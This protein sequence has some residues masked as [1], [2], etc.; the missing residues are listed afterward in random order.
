MVCSHFTGMAT[1]L[2]AITLVAFSLSSCTETIGSSEITGADPGVLEAPIAF[3]KRPIPV[4]DNDNE[5]QSDLREPLFFAAGGDIYLR[6]NSTVTA[7]ELNITA[8]ITAGQGDVKD[9]KPSFDGTRLL[10]SLRLFDPNPNDDDTPSW[11][12]YEYDLAAKTTRRIISNDLTAEQGDDIGPAYLPDG[13]IVFSSNRQRQSGEMLTNEGKPRFRALDED[14]N[15]VAMVLHVMDSDGGNLQQISFNQSHDLDPLVLSNSYPGEIA[16]T[17]WDNTASNDAMHLYKINPDGSALQVLYGVHS[18]D[19]GTNNAGTNDSTIQFTQAEEMLD[20]RIMAITR[21]Y[22]GTYGGGNIVI[23]DIENFVNQTQPVFNMTGLPGPAQTPATINNVSTAADEISTA[24]RYSAAYPLWD[25]SNRIL[26][27]KSI[28]VL[29]L[30]GISR[31]CI[32]PYLS[33][34]DSVEVSPVYGIWLY[35][36]SNNTE[37]IIILAEQGMVITDIVALQSRPAPMI[38]SNANINTL[39]ADEG[40]AAVHVKSVYDFGNAG[41]DGCFLSECSS[42]AG[43]NSVNDLGDPMQATAD[44]RPARFIRL[45]KAVALPD[46]NDPDLGNDAPNLNRAAFGPSR[47]QGMREIIG[48]APVE[49]DGS[50]KVKVPANIPLAINVLDKSGRRIGARHENWFQLKPG[51]T[52]T[53]TGCHTHNTDNNAAPEIHHR[54][55]AETPSINTGIPASG[56]FENTRIPGSTDVYFGNPGETMAEVRFKL[57]TTEPQLSPDLFYSDVWTN[58]DLRDVDAA[59]SLEYAN[60]ATPPPASN[61]CLRDAAAWDF[62]CRIVINYE[63]HIHPMWSVPRGVDGANTCTNCHTTF[64][65]TL[66]LDKVADGQLDLTDGFSDQQMARF[67]SYRELFFSDA[68]QELDATGTLVNIQI[69]VPILDENGAPAVDLN[70]TPLTEFI[71]DPDASTAA[72]MSANGARNSY[73]MEKMTETELIAGR[74]LLSPGQANYLNHS[75]FMS[76][77]ELRLISEWLDI[78]AQYFNDPFDPDVPMN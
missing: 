42:A 69:E 60:L 53:C 13:R 44:Q 70:G 65:N 39:W 1:R 62:K 29:K 28:C 27:S 16:F 6:S 74:R 54:P 33:N 66:M 32:E 19:T 35:D 43:I 61:N 48:Y 7:T 23:I 8:D 64:D 57:A 4:D 26:V 68:G 58:P 75:T 11:N 14:R 25:G 73:F 20:G 38:K 72:S 67:K 46:R 56:I 18:H 76:A 78:G 41:F 45:I 71:D 17:R 50:V 3:V 34:V 40:M 59:F 5:M 15:T 63:Q 24:G 31:P 12:I 36:V 21:P 55:D 30:D 2:Y 77:D 49:P 22:T 47:N 52:M 51:E 37:R 10:F 9:L